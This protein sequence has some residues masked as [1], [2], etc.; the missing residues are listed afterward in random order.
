MEHSSTLAEQD[1]GGGVNGVAGTV[2]VDVIRQTCGTRR[3]MKWCVFVC[4]GRGGFALKAKY[5]C[6]LVC[7]WGGGWGLPY[8]P[9]SKCSGWCVCVCVCARAPKALLAK[10]NGQDGLARGKC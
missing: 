7:V 3:S 5:L 8:R 6:W 1:C 2:G 9:K 4:V 10:G